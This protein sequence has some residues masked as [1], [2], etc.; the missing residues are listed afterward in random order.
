MNKID[1]YNGDC[2][3]VMD[4][5]IEEGIK[6]DAI[7][8]DPPYKYLKNQ[9][10]ETDWDE[11]TFFLYAKQVLK[12]DGFIVMFG[13]GTSFYRWNTILDDMGFIFKEEI[14]WDKCHSTS[15][16]L[17]ISRV[18]ETISI[19][20]KGKG[21]INKIKLPYIKVRSEKDIDKAIA[22]VNRIKGVLNSFEKLEEVKEYLETGKLQ[23]GLKRKSM[24][25]ITSSN[26][27]NECSRF[28]ATVRQINEGMLP[29][30]IITERREHY[31]AV[32][33]TQKPVKLLETLLGLISKESDLILD[34]FMGSGTTGIACKNL[35]RDFIGIELDKEY[36]EI[37]KKRI[38]SE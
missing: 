27:R 25:N 13:R 38:E 21:K 4:K 36:F 20:S 28:M 7:V 30:S 26:I 19:F 9:K 29:K 37:A 8:T 2:L 6:V 35:N 1:L 15:P 14:V 34:S 22:D 10:L 33:P 3:K 11:K 5:L 23:K 16:M 12:K 32:H 17:P 24:F 18:H 31:N